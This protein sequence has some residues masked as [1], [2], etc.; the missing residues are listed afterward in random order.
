MPDVHISRH[1][2]RW[3]VKESPGA[4]P[5]FEALTRAEAESEARRHAAGGE[6][7]WHEEPDATER[8][9]GDDDPG[10]ADIQHRQGAPGRGGETFREP[11]AGL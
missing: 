8:V 6:L 11:Q 7:H 3:A 9:P 4:T 5:F 10:P 1:G 2:D